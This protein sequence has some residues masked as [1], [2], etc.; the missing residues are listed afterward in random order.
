M[1]VFQMNSLIEVISMSTTLTS[2]DAK[3][4]KFYLYYRD[5]LSYKYELLYS[6]TLIKQAVEFINL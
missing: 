3:I 5:I 2:F 6:P 4:T 1:L